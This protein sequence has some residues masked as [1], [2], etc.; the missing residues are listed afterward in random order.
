VA[1]TERCQKG[2]IT[3]HDAGVLTT[4]STACPVCGFDWSVDHATA[5]ALVLEAPARYAQTFAGRDGPRSTF[6]GTLSPR[7]HLWFTVDILRYGAE[8]LWTLSLDP[9]A[10]VMPWHPRDAHVLRQASPMSVRVGLW[11]LTV[12]SREGAL[13]ARDAPPDVSAWH[14]DIGWMD[15]LLMVRRD[16]HEVVHRENSIRRLLPDV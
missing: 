2:G 16:A 15:R 13:A 7:E 1:I 11:A 8:R 14:D 12:A 3:G 10:G 5:I 9:D 6:D 4:P